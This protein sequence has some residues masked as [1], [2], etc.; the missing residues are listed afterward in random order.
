MSGWNDIENR[1][2]ALK[3]EIAAITQTVRSL[4]KQR[5]L[6]NVKRA[7]KKLIDTQLNAK[8][9]NLPIAVLGTGQCQ[10]QKM[11]LSLIK[12]K[13]RNSSS[14]RPAKPTK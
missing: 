2:N 1:L 8:S 3:A 5:A 7:E 11:P 9:L 4:R 6:Y 10:H 13:P 12:A 14:G